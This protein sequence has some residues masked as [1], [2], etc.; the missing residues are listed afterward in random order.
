MFPT[1]DAAFPLHWHTQSL[2]KVGIG[3]K[4]SGRCACAINA[5]NYTYDVMNC[6]SI[7]L[8]ITAIYSWL[9]IGSGF[10]VTWSFRQH[11]SIGSVMVLGPGEWWLTDDCVTCE[12]TV[13]EALP[14]RIAKRSKVR[15][16]ILYF[17]CQFWPSR[18]HGRVFVFT[19]RPPGWQT[20]KIV[21]VYFCLMVSVYPKAI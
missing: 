9:Y 10:M 1:T 3:Q 4:L 19:A 15:D 11:L 21:S 7:V 17:E 6:A 13:Y 5:S 16:V 2:N 20:K 14:N 18:S 8:R 12:A